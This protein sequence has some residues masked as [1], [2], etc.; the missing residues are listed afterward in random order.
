VIQ[1]KIVESVRQGNYIE[2]AG[3]LAGVHKTTI[4]AWLKRGATAKSG[5]YRRFHNAVRQAMAE[6]EVRNLAVIDKAGDHDWRSAAWRLERR[7]PKR[8]GRKQYVATE[9]RVEIHHRREEA[10]R[11]MKDPEAREL[12][13][14][15]FEQISETSDRGGSRENDYST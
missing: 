14:T 6:S 13:I 11:V 8:W 10:R 9:A 5:S 3:V 2:T 12:A 1:E 4:Y 7:F 15:L